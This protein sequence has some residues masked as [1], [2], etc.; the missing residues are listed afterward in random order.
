[1]P[2]QHPP[3]PPPPDPLAALRAVERSTHARL[4][5]AGAPSL[6]GWVAASAA[7]GVLGERLAVTSAAVSTLPLFYHAWAAL[8]HRTARSDL[9]AAS[10]VLDGLAVGGGGG[11][12]A[13]AARVARSADGG[14]GLSDV[15]TG[16]EADA[17]ELGGDGDADDD[18][19]RDL[20]AVLEEE[21]GRSAAHRRTGAAAAATV[22]PLAPAGA[23][24]ALYRVSC[25]PHPPTTHRFRDVARWAGAAVAAGVAPPA[26]WRALVAET[27]SAPRRRRLDATVIDRR[28]AGLAAAL[29]ASF[30][31]A[32]GVEAATTRAP[33]AAALA[34]LVGAPPPPVA[35]PRPRTA[36][37][38]TRLVLTRPSRHPPDTAVA[39]S[40]G[41]ACAACGSLLTPP[42]LRCTH[43]GA[44]VCA[45]C[46]PRGR[47]V[48]LPASA[49]HT[50][51]TSRRP[52]SAPTAQS[53]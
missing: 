49:L 11:N 4:G 9:A 46:A 2:Q 32:G 31:A 24:H 37:R 5:A 6:T 22:T 21:G 27:R 41:G 20:A 19:W 52:A 15:S 53:F 8:R 23:T 13:R 3:P 39:A 34:S 16:D 44:L 42:T 17:D 25:P 14:G 26:P 45:P 40:Q 38:S 7:T 30:D 18:A 10:G 28:A 50:R 1:M 43:C 33:G 12:S 36:G 51:S 35:T 29:N 48:P 47:G